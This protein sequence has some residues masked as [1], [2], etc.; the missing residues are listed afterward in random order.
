[1]TQGLPRPIVIRVI[2]LLSPYV[3]HLRLEHFAKV[4]N[5]RRDNIRVVLDNV[6]DPLNLNACMRSVEAHGLKTVH[7]VDNIHSILGKS[8]PHAK[9]LDVK[10]E[11]IAR[12]LR[13]LRDEG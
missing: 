3:S 12:T 9:W 2:K 10:R 5:A 8:F 4:I 6:M 7:C 13:G 11:R 1:M